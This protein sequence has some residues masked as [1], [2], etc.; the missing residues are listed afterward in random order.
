[1]NAAA[2]GAALVCVAVAVSCA[3]VPRGELDGTPAS[4]PQRWE[5]SD[6]EQ[7]C[8][9]ETRAPEPSSIRV[10]CYAIDGVLHIH[11]TRFADGWRLFGESWVQKARRAPS[12]RVEVE[13]QV[14]SLRA[15]EVTD[16]ERREEI[17]AGR[18]F[19]P[20]PGGIRVFSF[21]ERPHER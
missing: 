12:V 13:G 4:A 20:V 19:D 5:F 14:F 9:I 18:G 10:G 7:P 15:L 1:M 17:L 6:P 16:P 11:S 3:A 21:E 2:R 8:W